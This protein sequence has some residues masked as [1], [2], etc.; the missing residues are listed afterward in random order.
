M[1]DN[2]LHITVAA[3]PE[4]QPG[5]PRI[6]DHD[7]RMVKASILYADKVK[8]CS[9][10]TSLVNKLFIM[11]E[12]PQTDAEKAEMLMAI[13]DFMKPMGLVID[14][15]TI[16][17]LLPIY[18]N[19]HKIGRHVL[20]ESERKRFDHFTE[21]INQFWEK[22]SDLGMNHALNIGLNEIKTA[23][24]QGILEIHQFE[25]FEDPHDY[26][27]EV[28]KFLSSASTHPML[29]EQTNNLVRLALK[30]GKIEIRKNP[31][32]RSKQASLVANLFDR[33]PVFDIKMDELL[34][35]RKELENPLIRFRAE[36]YNLTEEI[37][38]ASWDED[39]P[40]DVQG[41]YQSKIAPVLLEIEEK[42]QSSG[43]RDFWSRRI[44]EKSAILFG[45]GNVG[46]AI[47]AAISPFAGIFMA[48]LTGLAFTE[49]SFAEWREKRD[50]IQKNGLYFYYRM[51]KHS[52]QK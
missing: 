3:A 12:S 16:K 1:K 5:N 22:V 40:Y 19:V 6:I 50:E 17:E 31:N 38:S 30:E 20:P 45:G 34:D 37:E 36:I 46:Y 13:I 14:D 47:G 42:L 26:F 48:L 10:S 44:G 11:S 25:Q 39:F 43:L 23:T 32:L 51:I 9:L 35:L 15:T 18:I 4:S 33:L 28:E 52:E 27:Y 49:S 29:D 2:S 7:L 8:L 41:V 24:D 21:I